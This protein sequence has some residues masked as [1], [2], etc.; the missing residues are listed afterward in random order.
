MGSKKLYSRC[1]S[2]PAPAKEKTDQQ[3]AKLKV[4]TSGRPT[5]TAFSE[6]VLQTQ[7]SYCLPKS[8]LTLTVCLVQFENIPQS[9]CFGLRR[10][11]S[12]QSRPKQ[13]L[14]WLKEAISEGEPKREA[15][16]NKPQQPRLQPC[17]VVGTGTHASWSEVISSA[18]QSAEPSPILLCRTQTGRVALAVCCAPSTPSPLRC[19][20]TPRS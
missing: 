9:S 12:S 8:L 19:C 20:M 13:P 6:V 4:D 11:S 3:A 18:L 16:C 14:T 7:P 2:G 10:K 15:V 5:L 1:V 17:K